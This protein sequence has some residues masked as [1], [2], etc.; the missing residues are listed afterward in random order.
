MTTEFTTAALPAPL[1]RYFAA[2]M[3]LSLSPAPLALPEV[4]ISLLWHASYD[5]E[6]GHVW[7]RRAVMRVAAEKAA[8][9]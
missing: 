3:G 9:S 6:P 2:A 7:L 8:Q 1:A 4:S 5:H